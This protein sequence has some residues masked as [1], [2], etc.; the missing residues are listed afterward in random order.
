MDISEN[1]PFI[2]RSAMNS[3]DNGLIDRQPESTATQPTL[4]LNFR[5]LT[6]FGS[7]F[8]TGFLNQNAKFFLRTV[9]IP[10]SSINANIF[11]S[12]GVQFLT[13]NKT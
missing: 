9:D 11:A 1:F 2:F 4:P 5:A 6:C 12:S 13:E 10:I 8:P 3:G 7:L